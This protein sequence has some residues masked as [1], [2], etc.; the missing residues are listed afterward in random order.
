MQPGLC[1]VVLPRKPEVVG[2]QFRS[3]SGFPEGLVVRLPDDIL[4]AVGDHLRRAQ[5]IGVHG[6]N[7][8]A[9]DEGQGPA[10]QVD[11]FPYGIAAAVQLGDELAVAVIVVIGSGGAQLLHPLATAV[12]GVGGQGAAADT[13]FF[14]AVVL[15]VDEGVIGIAYSIA[16]GIIGV[17]QCAVDAG[18]IGQAVQHIVAEGLAA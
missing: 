8:P 1:V 18:S 3:H 17:G 10:V 7:I 13:G 16:V 5:M 6:V 11:V 4:T 14:Q 9:S 2:H 12:V 15:A